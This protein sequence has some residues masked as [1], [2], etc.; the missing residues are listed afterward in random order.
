M[1]N[2][3]WLRRA[4]EPVRPFSRYVE[5]IR[6]E[7]RA[8]FRGRGLTPEAIEQKVMTVSLA[9]IRRWYDLERAA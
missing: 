1:R 3:Q 2:T 7:F 9:A 5:R 8:A 4:A 6:D